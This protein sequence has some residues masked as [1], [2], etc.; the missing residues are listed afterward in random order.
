MVDLVRYQSADK[1]HHTNCPTKSQKTLFWRSEIC[2][3]W[4]RASLHDA[5]FLKCPTFFSLSCHLILLLN[6]GYVQLVLQLDSLFC[7]LSKLVKNNHKNWKWKII[8]PCPNNRHHVVRTRKKIPKIATR[9]NMNENETKKMGKRDFYIMFSR[10][11]FSQLKRC[12]FCVLCCCFIISLVAHFNLPPALGRNY[13]LS[14]NLIIMT[15][16]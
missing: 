15:I 2:K 7:V 12:V 16:V 4:N 8:L 10:F 11:L 13:F 5:T 1:L 9:I 3:Q 14:P 6:S